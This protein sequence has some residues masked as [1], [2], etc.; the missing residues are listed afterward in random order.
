M[1]PVQKMVKASTDSCVWNCF[2]LSFLDYADEGYQ[3]EDGGLMDGSEEEV[4]FFLFVLVYF[5]IL[6]SDF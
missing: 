3:P 1:E 4:D 6:Q 2:I 5:T